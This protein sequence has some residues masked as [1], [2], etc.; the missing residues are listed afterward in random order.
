MPCHAYALTQHG[1]KDL[2]GVAVCGVQQVSTEVSPVS[3][4]PLP[5]ASV[6]ETKPGLTRAEWEKLEQFTKP[7]TLRIAPSGMVTGCTAGGS[8]QGIDYTG[9]HVLV[10]TA[11]KKLLRRQLQQYVKC[12]NKNPG[13]TS[14]VVVLQTR[15]YRSA[16]L[17]FRRLNM[18]PECIMRK[19]LHGQRQELLTAWHDGTVSLRAASAA[20]TV[21]PVA[22][23]QTIS[24]LCSIAG[25]QARA[26]L[27]TGASHCFMRASFASE[28]GLEVQ[29]HTCSVAL[30]DGS[31]A[32]TSGKCCVRLQLG[33]KVTVVHCHVVDLASQYDI[34]L[35]MDFMLQHGVTITCDDNNVSVTAMHHGRTVQLPLAVGLHKAE[36]PA[37]EQTVV[38]SVLQ[39]K[40]ALRKGAAC[41]AVRITTGGSLDVHAQGP[42]VDQAFGDA[43]RPCTTEDVGLMR[44]SDLEK[45]LARFENKVFTNDA[46]PDMREIPDRG[47]VVDVLPL[48]PGSKPH[49]RKQYRM[50]LAEKEEITRRVR[51]LLEKGMIEPSK[52]PFSAPILFV[53]KSDGSL[54]MVLDYRGLNAMTVK[55]RYPIPRIDDLLDSIKN[56]TV[57]SCI[58]LASGYHQLELPE[59]DRPKT[60]FSTHMGHFQW[61][62]LPQGISNAPSVFQATMN[63][64]FAHMVGKHVFIYLDDILIASRNAEEHAKHLEEVLSVLEKN[65]LY[66]KR[67]KCSFNMSEVHYLGHIVGRG[68][69]RPDPRKVQVVQEWPRPTTA[70]EVRAFLG[71]TQYFRR[72]IKDYSLIAAP[73]H[74]LLQKNSTCTWSQQSEQAFVTLKQAL[75]SAPVLAVPNYEAPYQLEVWTD[76]SN[77]AVGAVLMQNGHPIA[78]E[79]RRFSGAE[80]NYDTT[81]REMVA[82]IHALRTWRCYLEGAQ[83]HVKCDHRALSFFKTKANVTPRQARWL[84]FIERFD[85][86]IDHIAGKNN[87]SDVLSRVQHGSDGPVLAIVSR[88]A[89][90]KRKLTYDPQTQD[91]CTWDTKLR[92]AVAADEWFADAGNTAGLRCQDGVW[93]KGD[94]VVVPLKL[95]QQCLHE[96]HD[97]PA[98]GHKGVNKTLELVRRTYWWPTIKKDVTAYVTTCASCQRNKAKNVLPGGT[99]QPLQIPEGRWH[100]VSMDYITGLPCTEAGYDSVFVVLDR[101]TKMAHFIPCTKDITAAKTADI[102]VREVIRLHGYPLEVISDRDP[103]FASEFWQRLLDLLGVKQRMSSAFHPQTDGG[104]ERINRILE[105]YLRAYVGAEQNDWDRWL[106]LAEFAYNNSRQDSTGYSPF[107]LNFGRHP[108]LPRTPVVTGVRNQSAAALA[109]RLDEHVKQ[110]KS[111]LEAAQQRQK[112]YADKKRREVVFAVGDQVMLDTRNIR[113]RTPG[114]Q[115]LMPKYIGPFTVLQTCGPVAYKLKLPDTMQRMHPV[116][117]ASLL[118]KYRQDGR[119]Q[120][121]PVPITF[122]DED[123]YELDAILDERVVRKGRRKITQYL[124]SFKGYGEEHNEWCDEDGVTETA[125]RAWRQSRAIAN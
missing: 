52:S 13:N 20:G 100:S 81:D 27:D 79:S 107:F 86:S 105:E 109:T 69:V 10:Q 64:L 11:D 33:R 14:A 50:T 123:W 80:R 7:F 2:A 49:F 102:F 83:F 22:A 96:A 101:L 99:L 76:A 112:H 3:L 93:Y 55:N 89:K 98:G 84:E 121:A 54:R 9:Q 85:L 24:L 51:E 82:I 125:V 45:I 73:L 124:C 16:A 23:Q 74:K 115:K 106:P 70:H 104:T 34:L 67:S 103:K 38:M 65:K 32:R 57:F 36:E 58:D 30:A 110:A 97:S 15:S 17:V 4:A 95:R 29:P 119:R 44:P 35:G 46:L 90:D 72:F 92:S 111:L 59:A 43:T 63:H 8:L 108:R 40:R 87:V 6:E 19:Q 116:F 66:A 91:T 62:V 114:Q 12:K 60:A 28:H 26:T 113:K 117:H 61:R 25:T 75:L 78:Y 39:M 88:K 68:G 42:V 118:H 1:V 71:L 94:K 31:T 77:T 37:P 122:M 48:I 47:V 5:Q 53:R 56:A 41:F 120:P 21:Q 18:N